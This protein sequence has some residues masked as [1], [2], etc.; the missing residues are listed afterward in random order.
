MINKD[1]ISIIIPVY[2]VEAY[3]Y[4]CLDSVINQ[5][6]Q[7]LQ[8]ILVDDGST[9]SSGAV[10]DFFKKKDS[11]I[12]VIHQTNAGLSAARNTGLSVAQGKYVCFIDS[13]DLVSENYVWTLYELQIRY[14]AQIVCCDY[15]RSRKV[16]NFHGQERDGKV[17]VMVS[18]EML[19]EW[20]G[21]NKRVETVVWNKLYSKELFIDSDGMIKFPEG[22]NHEDVCITH[23]LVSRSTKVV[24]TDL[25]LY[26][27]R[28]R[29]DSLVNRK[30][31]EKEIED[32]IY[33][34]NIRL[35]FFKNISWQSY[36]RL[37]IGAQKY[38][39]LYYMR[40]KGKHGLEKK[41]HELAELYCRDKN[42]VI[43]S[44]YCGISEKLIFRIFG[45]FV[46][47]HRG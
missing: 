11:R 16:P 35:D 8:I 22:R 33:A 30:I 10:C 12:E 41:C 17:K 43:H 32:I 46:S 24:I 42:V 7:K 14:N 39:I 34:H 5:R 15:I 13:D 18:R 38:R 4:Q 29:K 9:D 28:N 27:Y 47:K 6:Y 19:Q 45:L 21:M 36:E 25:K 20:H 40:T 23:Q 2:N 37:L 3:L 26:F 31:T 44:V 1:L